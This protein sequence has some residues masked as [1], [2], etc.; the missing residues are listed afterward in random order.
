MRAVP[1]PKKSNRKGKVK[2]LDNAFSLFIRARDRYVC[3]TCGLRGSYKDG[4][5]QCGHLFSRQSYST[6]WD[7]MNCYCQCKGCNNSHEYDAYPFTRYFIERYGLNAYDEL[8]LR[9]RTSRK[10]S[11]ADLNDMIKFY[12]GVISEFA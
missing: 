7:E 9:H 3:V 12:E 8:H 2:R 10:F 6:R 5:M 4:V 11:D 1:K